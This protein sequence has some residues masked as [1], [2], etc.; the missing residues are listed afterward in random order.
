MT[1]SRP[2]ALLGARPRID[3]SEW[4]S[5]PPRRAEFKAALEKVLA[6]DQWGLGSDAVSQFEAAFAAAH[7][8]TYCLSLAN[9]TVALY[10]ALAALDIRP[11]D[12]VIVPAYTFMA[13]V[14]AV[15]RAGATAV[16]ADIDPLT[17]NL[18]PEDTASRIN[19]RTRAIMP[20]HIGGNPADMD[21]FLSLGSEHGLAV[22][23]DAAQAHGA[24]YGGRKVGAQGLAG[25]FSFQ[26]SKN[27]T[28]GEGGALLTNDHAFYE[29]VYELA[30]CGRTPEGPAFMHLSAGLN[31]RLSAFQAAVLNAQLEPFES[32]AELRESNGRFLEEALNGI[33]GIRCAG[34]YAR[35]GRNAYHLLIFRYDPGAFAG[36][37]KTRFLEALMAEG[38]VAT[39]GYRPL[40]ELPFVNHTGAP[41]PVTEQLCRDQVWLR[42]FELLA[43][44]PLL[45][46]LVE[47]IQAIQ[48]HADL[49]LEAPHD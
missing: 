4:P 22:I 28:A 12:E 27:M 18:D 48:A 30:N 25:T 17:F 20:V 3:R 36:L 10:A 32:E 49:L 16:L 9:G 43:D 42:Q 33:P 31:L 35:T 8:A 19:G 34:R 40:Q 29:K 44:R 13:S 37:P 47:A 23:E 2:L 46:R 14:S 38:V 11:G 21:R 15:L 41:L 26:S 24:I 6:D 1:P 5:W 7:D 39:D 45:E